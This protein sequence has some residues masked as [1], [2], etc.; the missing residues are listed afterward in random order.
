MRR[1]ANHSVALMAK[2][3]APIMELINLKKQDMYDAA[4]AADAL[5]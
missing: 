4:R 1:I 3:L 2:A 5:G